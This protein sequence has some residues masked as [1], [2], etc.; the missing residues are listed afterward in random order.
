VNIILT[1]IGVILIVIIGYG[2]WNRLRVQRWLEHPLLPGKLVKS[3]DKHWYVTVKG[4][5]GPVVVID[6]AFGAFSTEWWGIQDRI[7]EFTTVVS[8]DRAGYGWS[9]KPRTPRTS[10]HIAQEL[11]DLLQALNLPG[12]FI[13]V[14]HSQ[15]GLYANHFARFFPEIIAGAVLL[16]PLSPDDN[17]FKEELPPKVYQQSGV[18]KS[19]TMKYGGWLAE[20]SLLPLLKSL[21]LQSPP[22]YYFHDFPHDRIEIIWRHMQ[23]PDYYRT[24]LDEYQQAHIQ[25]NNVALKTGG[26]FPAIPL[27]VLYHG[28]QIVI[29]E[30]VKYGGLSASEA[31]QVD[32]LWEELI[33]DYLTLSPKSEW[34]PCPGCSH[35]IHLGRPDLVIEA[36]RKVMAVNTN[37]N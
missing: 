9:D 4:T 23:R 35:Y 16:D 36:I 6:H 8:Y 1:L 25:A 12:P 37:S 20:L 27:M 22:F 24:A 31:A 30:I 34:I 32:H 21:L 2:V 19:A 15:G 7:A 28:P 14:G 29:D 3:G 18:D 33:R 5:G 26:N 10:Q 11:H 13:L 17:R